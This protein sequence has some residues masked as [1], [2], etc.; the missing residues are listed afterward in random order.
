MGNWGLVVELW[1]RMGGWQ[2]REGSNG[3]KGRKRGLRSQLF[4]VGN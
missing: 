3:D 1:S 2:V 4:M